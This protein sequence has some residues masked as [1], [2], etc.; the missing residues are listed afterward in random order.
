MSKKIPNEEVEEKNIK[1]KS[2][3]KGCPS[4]DLNKSSEET[5][6][7]L[8]PFPNLTEAS[9]PQH[10]VSEEEPEYSCNFF[11]KKFSNKQALGGH[12]NVHK[13]EKVGQKRGRQGQEATLGYPGNVFNSF[14]FPN[15]L[16][17]VPKM[18]KSAHYP[19]YMGHQVL[20]ECPGSLFPI[21]HESGVAQ[22][23]IIGRRTGSIGQSTSTSN[24]RSPAI[25]KNDDAEH[26][27]HITNAEVQHQ[28]DG[29][30]LSL[31]L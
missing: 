29:L 10:V 15:S 12:Q 23:F 16:D 4:L 17:Q 20:Y 18:F 6:L 30:Y 28:E 27:R 8:N 25:A 21:P 11:P 26:H 19:Q 24:G 9:E 31:K 2:V 14:P 22:P 7:Q 3:I 13:I 5:D 1:N